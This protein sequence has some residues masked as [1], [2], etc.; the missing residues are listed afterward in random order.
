MAAK[1][2]NDAWQLLHVKA[3]EKKRG[4]QGAPHA[5]PPS[6]KSPVLLNCEQYELNILL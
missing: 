1:A 2:D 3:I 5:T 4:D 6:S